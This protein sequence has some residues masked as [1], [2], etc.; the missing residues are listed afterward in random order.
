M[1]IATYKYKL[2][3]NSKVREK[4]DQ[5]IGTCRCIYNL[6]L[7]TKIYAYKA[8]NLS[9]SKFDLIKQLP[10]LKTEHSWMKDVHSQTLQ[11]VIERMDLSYQSFFRG[12]GFPKWAK[13]D[14]YRSFAFKQ[15]VKVV[16][17]HVYLP[18]IG[19]VKFRKSREMLGTLKRTTIVKEADGYYICFSCE[20]EITPKASNENQVGIDLGVAHFV[21]TSNGDLYDSNQV[22]KSHLSALRVEQRSLAR[23][24]KFGSNWYK[25]KERVARLHLKVKRVRKDHHHK[26]STQLIDQCGVL[27]LE[28]LK[29]KNMTRSS[30]GSIDESGKRVKAKSGLNRSILDAGMG[31][32]GTML[33]YKAQW[34]GRTIIKVDPKYTSQECTACGH[35]AKENRSGIK[36]KCASCGHEAHADVNAAK[37]ILARASASGSQ[38]KAVA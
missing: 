19:K 26:L 2:V 31:M 27:L 16:D 25:Q 7:E 1:Q 36:F 38:R 34:Y 32:F 5:W 3:P 33:E 20:V 35:R 17:N 29:L 9:L 11:D 15:G 28:D 23:K 13:K 12:G 21:A 22:L 4:F 37:N 14:T 8:H 24:K 6:A 10:E 18:K 30:K